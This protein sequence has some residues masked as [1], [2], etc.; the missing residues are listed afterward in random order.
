MKKYQVLDLQGGSFM[1]DTHGNPLSALQ[2]RRRF[3]S[4]EDAR[5]SRFSEFT[6]DYIAEMWHV[7]FMVAPKGY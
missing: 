5:T 2:L 4:L 6:L 3:W 1:S 7:R